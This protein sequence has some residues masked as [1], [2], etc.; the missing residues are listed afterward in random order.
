MTGKNLNISVIVTTYQR[1][2]ALDLTLSSLAKQKILPF[3]IIV[4]DDGSSEETKKLVNAWKAKSKIPVIHCWHQDIGF[5]A[6]EIRNKA[7]LLA[8]GNYLVFLDG[9]CLVFP[10]FIEQHMQLAEENWMVIGSRILCT[11]TLHMK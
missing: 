8:T 9:D 11:K 10:D 6:A 7:V 5:R 1:P 3:E 2:V 4:A